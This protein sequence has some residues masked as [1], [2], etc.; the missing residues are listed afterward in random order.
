MELGQPRRVF[1]I[2]DNERNVTGQ[3]AALMAIE[4]ILQAVIVFRDKDR[5]A[6]TVRSAG[7]VLPSLCTSI[8]T[9]GSWVSLSQIS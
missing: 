3:L 9:G 1:V 4:E 2:A 8:K 7:M 6:L 5:D